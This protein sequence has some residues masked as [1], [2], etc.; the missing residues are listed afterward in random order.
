[1]GYHRLTGWTPGVLG[2]RFGARLPGAVLHV[3]IIAPLLLYGQVLNVSLL[4]VSCRAL[5]AELARLVVW[6]PPTDSFIGC[7]HPVWTSIL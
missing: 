2:G 6:V 1:M 5:Q 3:S 7:P 4:F